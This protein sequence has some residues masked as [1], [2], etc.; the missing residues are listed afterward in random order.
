MSEQ[1]ITEKLQ[2][3]AIELACLR[4]RTPA[5]RKRRTTPRIGK[6]GAR[7]LGSKSRKARSTKRR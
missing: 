3:L 4:M 1:A 6:R 2:R 5:K 7:T